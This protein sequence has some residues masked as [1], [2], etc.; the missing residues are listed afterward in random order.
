MIFQS[1][2]K[3]SIHSR[4]KPVTNQNVG[5]TVKEHAKP[6]AMTYI[7]NGPSILE[8]GKG[9]KDKRLSL[10]SLYLFLDESSVNERALFPRVYAELVSSPNDNKQ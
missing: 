1:R 3:I 9:K 8:T 2:A 5:S 7:L 10:E 4:Q 6:L